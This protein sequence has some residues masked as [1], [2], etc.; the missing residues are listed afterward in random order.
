V[1]IDRVH[2]LAAGGSP[3]YVFQTWEDITI[4]VDY[5]CDGAIPEESL[6]IAIGI[7]RERDLLLVAQ[8]STCAPTGE[9]AGA[10]DEAPHR[11]TRSYPVGRISATLP[12]QRM[13]A[14][15]Y[16][17]SVGLQANTPMNTGFYEY[18]HQVYHIR[19]VPTGYPSG[20]IFYPEVIWSHQ[21]RTADAAE[22]LALA[23]HRASAR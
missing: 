6:G 11:Q 23:A 1:V 16:L 13:L 20:A 21:E 2:F 12:R 18:H 3:R 4:A 9:E 7:E 22:P 15:D 8:F 5:H 10:Y 17:V 19:V 14:G